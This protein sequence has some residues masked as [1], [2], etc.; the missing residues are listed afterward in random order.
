M[1]TTNDGTADPKLGVIVLGA[2][3]F[4]GFPEWQGMDNPSFARSAAAFRNLIDDPS[5]TRFGVP[6]ML[7]L[8]D[9]TE[10]PTDIVHTVR[11]FLQNRPS[12]TDVIFYYCGY[13][14]FLRDPFRTFA[15]LLRTTELRSEEVTALP[16]SRM[17][18]ALDPQVEAKRV[19]L[20][21][22]CGIAGKVEPYWHS[23]EANKI[24]E[25]QIGQDHQIMQDTAYIVGLSIDK[26]KSDL[27]PTGFTNFTEDFVGTISEGIEEEKSLLS[28]H[29]VFQSMRAKIGSEHS[30][31]NVALELIVPFRSEEKDISFVPLFVNRAETDPRKQL[32]LKESRSA[33]RIVSYS[34]GGTVS[35]PSILLPT[36]KTNLA[37]VEQRFPARGWLAFRIPRVMR[38]HVAEEAEVRISRSEGLAIVKAM[39]GRGPVTVRGV[40]VAEAMSLRLTAPKGGFTISAHSSETQ[41][42]HL[43]TESEE[44]EV[45]SWRFTVT[46]TRRGRNLLRITLAYRRI[47]VEG[48][49]ADSSLPDE[50]IDVHVKANLGR[51]CWAA[52]A[53]T[54]TLLAGAALGAY[55]EN[56]MRWL[57]AAIG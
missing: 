3:E 30:R 13:G 2:S 34:A 50:T 5:G 6:A 7:D 51:V 37:S 1:A 23:S 49:V 45:A 42:V 52:A 24:I 22:D 41:W 43:E 15:L 25:D 33:G 29:D 28:F 32:L 39:V 36:L 4:P 35:S 21:L 16:L 26:V 12:L 46:A 17:I 56:M 57:S 31:S 47:G 38:V 14:Y 9:S 11:E 20:I 53:W 55:F 18:Q 8:F 40:S 19:Y 10:G 27:N 54:L 44:A 48:I